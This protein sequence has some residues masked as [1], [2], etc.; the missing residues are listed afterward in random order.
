MLSSEMIPSKK[1]WVLVK[2][3]D[4]LAKEI[5]PCQ[6]DYFLAKRLFP[7]KGVIFCHLNYSFL[8]EMFSCQGESFPV[9]R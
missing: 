2:G 1:K 6:R 9:I 7:G 8:T 4:F 5:I 3:N